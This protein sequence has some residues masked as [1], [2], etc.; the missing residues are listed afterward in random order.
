MAECRYTYIGLSFLPKLPL[1][2]G[3]LGPHLTW[4]PGPTRVLDPN[5]ISISSAIFAGLTSVTGRQTTILG[6]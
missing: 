2:M 6:R 1:P 3:Y 5:G 4:F